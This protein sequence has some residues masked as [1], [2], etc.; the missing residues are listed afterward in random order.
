MI[1]KQP[2]L[3]TLIF[4]LITSFLWFPTSSEADCSDKFT[5]LTK[6]LHDQFSLERGYLVLDVYEWFP[7]DFGEKLFRLTFRRQSAE[8]DGVYILLTPIYVVSS[9]NPFPV[10]KNEK[11]EPS[12]QIIKNFL[13]ELAGLLDREIKSHLRGQKKNRMKVEPVFATLRRHS[14]QT[15]G[16]VGPD[17]WH[18]DTGDVIAVTLAFKGQGTEYKMASDRSKKA[19]LLHAFI[20]GGEDFKISGSIQGLKPTLHRTPLHVKK[21]DRLVLIAKFRFSDSDSIQITK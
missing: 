9:S 20:F 15:G 5:K 7:Q 3:K 6:A 12:F 19:P 16:V 18:L 4:Y 8:D 13:Y 21:T 17:H 11:L 10:V 2:S 14:A 1:M